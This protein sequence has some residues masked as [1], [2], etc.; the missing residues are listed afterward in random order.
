ME[1]SAEVEAFIRDWFQAMGK[2]DAAALEGLVGTGPVRMVGTDTAEWWGSDPAEVRRLMTAQVGEM[3]GQMTFEP[4]DLEGYREG[5]IGWA[6]ARP[7]VFLADGTSFDT[8]LTAVLRNEG[9]AW[10]LIQG[11]LSIGIANEE[12]FGQELTTS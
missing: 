6:A 4:Y 2:G 5:T 10:C 12:T 1:R 7:R 9:A 11:H 3:A 8:R